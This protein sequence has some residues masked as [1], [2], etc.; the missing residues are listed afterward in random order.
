MSHA[1]VIKYQTSGILWPALF[2]A[3]ESVPL[4]TYSQ[5]L[6]CTHANNSM[7]EYADDTYIVV[8]EANVQSCAAEIANVELWLMST[9]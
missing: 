6:I 7:F 1:L 8:P 3:Q 2:N 9:I 5:H 4:P